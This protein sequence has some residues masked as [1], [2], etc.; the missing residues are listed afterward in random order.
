MEKLFKIE[1]FS[2]T[3]VFGNLHLAAM[4]S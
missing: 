1:Q 4:P 3:R 2:A